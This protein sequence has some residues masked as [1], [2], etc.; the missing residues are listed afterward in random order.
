MSIH[1]LTDIKTLRKKYHLNQKELALRA[2]VSQSLIAKIE[3]GTVDPSFTK[4]QQIFDAL[5]RIR[6]KEEVK[7]SELMRTKVLFANVSESVKDVIQLMK[8]KGISQVPVMNKE[9]VVGIISEGNILEKIAEHPEKINT[10]KVGE[11]MAEVPPIVT[12]DTGMKMLLHLLQEFPIVLVAEKGDI[13][14]IISKT[15]L[16]GKIE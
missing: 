10:L 9:K 13:K 2:Q 11:V 15:D 3:S 1:S 5:D 4:A 12:K 6:E 8:N 14:G 16:L 7:A